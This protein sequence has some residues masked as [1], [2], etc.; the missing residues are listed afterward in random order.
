MTPQEKAH[1]L[2]RNMY[3]CEDDTDLDYISTFFGDLYADALY[4]A[5]IFV[6]EIIKEYQEH[7]CAIVYDADFP[8]FDGRIKYWQEVKQHLESMQF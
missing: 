8:L 5:K 3:G 7:I 1:E 2:V 6:D 4:S